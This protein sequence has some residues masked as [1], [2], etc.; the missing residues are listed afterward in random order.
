MELSELSQIKET[1]EIKKIKRDASKLI[2]R[3]EV[4]SDPFWM[5]DPAILFKPE[6]LNQFFPTYQ[7]TFIEKL[8]AITR[9]AIYL[10][11]ALYL[12][13]SNYNWLYLA[14]LIP[15]F[16]IFMY[17][18]QREN[19]ETYFNNYDSLENAINEAELLTPETVKPTVNN[20]FMNINLITDDRTRAP[21]TP[22]WNN[23][24]VMADIEDKF[25]YNLYRDT[26]DLYGK[27]NSQ[28]QYVTMPAT[29]IPNDQ[30][31]FAKWLYQTGPTCKEKAVYCAPEF[32]PFPM[33]DTSNPYEL[34]NRKV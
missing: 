13:S 25:N 11:L 2:Q 26:G 19:I 34:I 29:T 6:R 17:K 12:V 4:L 32:N 24:E 10:G 15:I 30:T 21:A 5:E 18:T 28:R 22:S 1:P 23:D 3:S 33:V 8:N 14:V 20:P 31:T 7:M 27:N 16:T 9:L